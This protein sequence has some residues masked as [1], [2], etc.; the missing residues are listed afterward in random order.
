M[1]LTHSIQERLDIEGVKLFDE[2]IRRMSAEALQENFRFVSSPRVNA[3]GLIKSLIWQ[4]YID[5]SE[6]RRPPIEGNIRSFW[7]TDV[8]PVL[9]RAGLNVSGRQYVERVYDQFVE[10]V[11]TYHLFKYRDFGFIDEGKGSRRIGRTNGHVI[12]MGEKQGLFPIIDEL[13]AEVDCTGV[14]LNGYSSVLATEYL[15]W[16]I[17][18]S[19]GLDREFHLFAVVDY[20][21]GGYWV[22]LDYARQLEEFGLKSL[23]VHS[24]ITPD[25][26]AA[27]KL[28]MNKIPLSESA[29]AQNWLDQTGGIGGELYGLQADAFGKNEIRA[30]FRREAGPY[31]K[32]VTPEADNAGG[33][34]DTL[35]T[36]VRWKRGTLSLDELADL[37]VGLDPA[38]LEALQQKIRERMHEGA[39][40]DPH[41]EKDSLRL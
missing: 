28:E 33:L 13:A 24:L 18:K 26:L 19:G 21:P 39:S 29:R 23:A 6:G 30:I 4:A 25:N 17:E 12:L 11:M 8:K 34:L 10:Y 41:G 35:D 2:D 7:Y 14:A 20:D 27:E 3:T 36:L 32:P 9:A 1:H 16:A 15:V 37:I 38:H 5:I 40:F 22:A 31:L